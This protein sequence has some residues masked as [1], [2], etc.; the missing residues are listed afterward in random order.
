[1]VNTMGL[2]LLAVASITAAGDVPSTPVTVSMIALQ[3][4]DETQPYFDPQLN[5]VRH[6]LADVKRNTFRKIASRQMAAPYEKDTKLAINSRYTL[7][8]TPLSKEADGRVRARA[9]ITLAPRDGQ[10]KSINAVD[11]TLVIVPGDYVK[12][13]GLKLDEGELVVLLTVS[14]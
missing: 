1:M 9:R 11:T 14:D 4:T 3:A 2:I 5:T 7:Y 6:A 8:I 10:G 12:I 13:R